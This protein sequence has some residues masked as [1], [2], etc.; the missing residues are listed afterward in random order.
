MKKKTG[1][2]TNKKAKASKKP[3]PTTKNKIR[4][5]PI[6][7]RPEEDFDPFDDGSLDFDGAY[8]D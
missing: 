1:L 5:R 3:K 7:E 8:V 4:K 6:K 2:L